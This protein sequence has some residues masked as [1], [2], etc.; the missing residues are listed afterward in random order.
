VALL[1]L[2]SCAGALGLVWYR[3]QLAQPAALVHW[4]LASIPG[5][6]ELIDAD[7]RSLGRTPLVVERPAAE[8]QVTMI[9][10]HA[11]YADLSVTFPAGKD[12]AHT[13]SLTALPQ[14]GPTGPAVVTVDPVAADLGAR[15]AVDGGS[16]APDSLPPADLKSDEASD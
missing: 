14:L 4:S 13:E 11:G 8:G 2:L 7:G 9:L 10:R 16:G 12:A 6:A 15:P 5:D 1:L 3:R